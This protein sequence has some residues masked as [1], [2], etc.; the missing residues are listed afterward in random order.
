MNYNRL[1]ILL[2]IGFYLLTVF[3]ASGPC[4]AQLPDSLGP[5]RLG[6]DT[7]RVTKALRPVLLPFSGRKLILQN[8][9]AREIPQSPLPEKFAATFI[10]TA[11]V[12]F[13]HVIALEE[14]FTS[15]P[16]N[17]ADSSIFSVQTLDTLLWT[18]AFI[19]SRS[20]LQAYRK[21]RDQFS[22]QSQEERKQ[23][24]DLIE[25]NFRRKIDVE[26]TIRSTSAIAT[27]LDTSATVKVYLEKNN[28]RVS[29]ENL[30][31]GPVKTHVENGQIWY[32]R[33][34]KLEFPRFV[35]A[36]DFWRQNTLFLVLE[37]KNENGD[38]SAFRLLFQAPR[39]K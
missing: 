16:D 11:T 14:Y 31:Y 1:H 17:P 7:I 29:P 39:Q 30:L 27:A 12:G 10:D 34:V 13:E 9:I 19:K 18:S 25:K 20:Y 28:Q 8:K 36:R 23:F 21:A 3:A 32:E 24:D 38:V 37:T 26:L 33:A 15:L 2:Q 35:K 22:F 6:R 5:P 4:L